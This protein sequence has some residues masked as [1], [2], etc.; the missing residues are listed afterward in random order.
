MVASPPLT[1][2]QVRALA[3]PES[4]RRGREYSQ[5]GAVE[6]PGHRGD[7]LE[8]EVAGSQYEPYQVTVTRG[9]AG[10][11]TEGCTC[12]YDW[13]GACKHVVAA[14]L[15]YLGDPDAVEERPPLASVLAPLN[16]EQ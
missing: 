16:R 3:S 12:P 6:G 1:E 4:F 8:A 11:V 9:P 13:G 14:L 5:Q 7:R 15:A 2:A 10:V